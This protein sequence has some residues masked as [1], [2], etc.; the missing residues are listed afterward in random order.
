MRKIFISMLAIVLAVV[1]WSIPLQAAA[2]AIT[3][4]TLSAAMTAGTNRMTVA[5]ATG[6]TASSGTQQYIVFVDTEAMLITAVSGTT[7]TVIR[8]QNQSSQSAHNSGARA[9]VG[10]AGSVSAGSV[11]GGPF[12]QST[13]VGTCD[14]NN[15]GTLP[16]I[17]VRTARMVNC[18]GGQWLDQTLPN[19]TSTMPIV[20]A[21]NVPIGSVAYASVGT[22]TADIANKRMTTSIWVPQSVF[23]TGLQVLQG[24]TATTDTITAQLADSGGKVFAPGA[25]AGVALSGANTFL[26]VPFAAAQIITG[27]ALYFASIV[28]NGATAGAY[29]TVPTATFKNVVS[30]GTTSITFGTFPN[31]TPPTTFTA[32]LA[33][34]VCLYN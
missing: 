20:A 8:G 10:A 16:L 12:V 34:V 27:P 7:I 13:P 19:G 1:G 32:D 4:T 24:G 23:A 31:F 26:S 9:Y 2:S 14:R 33:P 22:N 28:G 18:N 3:T 25:A 15:V 11:T 30:Q 5:S 6:F 29:Q 21:C 17:N